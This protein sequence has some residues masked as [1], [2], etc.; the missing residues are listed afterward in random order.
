M[1]AA[2][3]RIEVIGGGAMLRASAALSGAVALAEAEGFRQRGL[4]ADPPSWSVAASAYLQAMSPWS[5]T[6]CGAGPA[7]L[8]S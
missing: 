4:P 8:W 3:R 7:A 6:P 5:W 1:L 2:L